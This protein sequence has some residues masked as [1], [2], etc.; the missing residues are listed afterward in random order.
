MKVD[1]PAPSN[2]YEPST[3]DEQ[4]EHQDVA[5]QDHQ[6]VAQQDP[7]EGE[8]EEHQVEEPPQTDEAQVEEHEQSSAE[9]ELPLTGEVVE[10][11][12]SEDA[13]APHDEVQQSSS[14]EV[15]TAL[16]DPYVGGDED[17]AG[18]P[19]TDPMQADEGPND[20]TNDESVLGMQL[21]VAPENLV[22][23]V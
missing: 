4:E 22:P 5:Q 14:A 8:Q 20:A 12:P 1:G 7:Q 16:E 13:D 17:A 10:A 19:E 21:D 9:D 15:G 11:T 18:E 6:D 3:P 2:P 23:A